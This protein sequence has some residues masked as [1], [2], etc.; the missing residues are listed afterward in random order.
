[1]A[2]TKEQVN[3]IYRAKMQFLLNK[4][5]K[6]KQDKLDKDRDAQIKH[7]KD[8]GTLNLAA[9]AAN[10]GVK[11]YDRIVLGKLEETYGVEG[12]DE[13]PSTKALPTKY[14][15]KP[16]EETTFLERIFDPLEE[17]EQYKE[18]KALEETGVDPESLTG[19]INPETGKQG[20]AQEYA[21]LV[22]QRQ[23]PGVPTAPAIDVPD[24]KPTAPSD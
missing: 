21:R 3:Q 15:R 7:E 9:G 19:W 12:V 6:D 16:K 1:M 11:W 22:K 4:I 14:K 17:R 18:F 23:L 10:M 13:L 24:I 5:A 2:Y 20:T 8:I